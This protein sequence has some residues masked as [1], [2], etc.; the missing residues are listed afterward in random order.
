MNT[1]YIH[2]NAASTGIF[3]IHTATRER[4]FYGVG[5]RARDLAEMDISRWN[6]NPGLGPVDFVNDFDGLLEKS[7][8]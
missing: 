2:E 5:Y 3:V 4:F 7:V 6:K 8:R 1:Y